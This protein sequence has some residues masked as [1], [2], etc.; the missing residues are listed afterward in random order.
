MLQEAFDIYMKVMWL[1]S[2]RYLQ[3]IFPEKKSYCFCSIM[4]SAII[5]AC[6]WYQHLHVSFQAMKFVIST[7]FA[8]LE[9]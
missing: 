5:I 6:F 9:M 2:C 3:Y 7:S 1:F 4:G 8:H